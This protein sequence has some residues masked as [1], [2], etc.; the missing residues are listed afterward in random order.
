MMEKATEV[1]ASVVD[2]LKS[3]PLMLALLVFNAIF[4]AV[5][6]FNQKDVRERQREMVNHLLQNQTKMQETL[7]RCAA[8]RGEM[9][10]PGTTGGTQ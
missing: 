8:P 4:F 9:T 2:S 10:V 6:Y 5:F 7:A 1:A 3:Q